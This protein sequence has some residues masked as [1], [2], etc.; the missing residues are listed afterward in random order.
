[1]EIFLEMPFL[2]IG[3]LRTSIDGRGTISLKSPI[4]GLG[5]I[6][7]SIVGGCL[8]GSEIIMVWEMS[9][10]TV[11]RGS[12][13]TCVLRGRRNW[14]KLLFQEKLFLSF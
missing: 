9:K 13:S 7:E 2:G 4:R 8:F 10:S 11:E 14:R 5:V 12:P 3:I 6:G 1:M